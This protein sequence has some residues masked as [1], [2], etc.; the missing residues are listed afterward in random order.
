M[1]QQ[2]AAV[3]DKH[4]SGVC[5]AQHTRLQVQAC[6]LQRVIGLNHVGSRASGVAVISDR[7]CT[8]PHRELCSEI[9]SHGRKPADCQLKKEKARKKTT[10]K[11]TAAA[12][13]HKQCAQLRK[14]TQKSPPT[15]NHSK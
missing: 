6:P 7:L 12:E 15:K 8:L 9:S 5:L 1:A 10:Q 11:N 4:D 2:T 14:I 13:E 3:R